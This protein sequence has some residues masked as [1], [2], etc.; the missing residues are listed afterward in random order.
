MS[1]DSK[2]L[3]HVRRFLNDTDGAAMVEAK[4]SDDSYTSDGERRVNITGDLHIT[5]CN[6]S[7]ELDMCFDDLESG[8]R[9]LRKLD[10]LIDA[11]EQLRDSVKRVMKREWKCK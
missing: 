3:M 9:I 7:I 10:R 1:D 5:D 4:L 2:K 6:R 11:A 8:H